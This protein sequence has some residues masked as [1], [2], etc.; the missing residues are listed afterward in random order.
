M[1][2]Q[3]IHIY[4]VNKRFTFCTRLVMNK[5]LTAP[6]EIKQN[7]FYTVYYIKDYCHNNDPS[8][9]HQILML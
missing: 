2:I 9:C 6:E 1:Y 3:Y 7:V 8:V 4:Y 5:C